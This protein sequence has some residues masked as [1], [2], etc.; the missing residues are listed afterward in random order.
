MREVAFIFPGQGSQKVGMGKDLAD[1]FRSARDVFD[2][3]DE[4]L[5]ERLSRLIWEGPD[6]LLRLTVNAQPALMTVSCAVIRVLS[7]A[8]ITPACH[9][10]FVAGHSLGEYSALA[11]AGSL[12]LE[13]AARLLR[14]RGMSMQQ[15]VSLGKGRM[16]ALLGLD[17]VSVVELVA[18]ASHSGICEVAN[19][20]GPEQVI[21][22]GLSSAVEHA[23]QLAND[24]G[25]KRVVPLDV[26]APFH[27]SLM[28]PAAEIIAE[29]LERIEIHP[30]TVDVIPNVLASPVRAPS[31]IRSCLVEQMTET[32]RWRESL[33]F[34]LEQG[35][36]A[37]YELGCGKVL[38]GLVRSM[39]RDVS[40]FPVCTPKQIETAAKLLSH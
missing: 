18:E 31:V 8:G 24:R 36:R 32:V 35:V 13:D 3:V 5:G 9:A 25:V 22:S 23:I 28:S 19:D 29:A 15:A 33:S 16:V 20:N 40:A 7:E 2:A 4:A 10:D 12:S 26:S 1:A 14:L 11:A 34:M 37:F 38:S 17:F 39:D 30:A 27:C 6:E 21:I